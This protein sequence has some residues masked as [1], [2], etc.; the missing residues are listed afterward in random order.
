V[1]AVL[2]LCSGLA[3][4]QDARTVLQSATQAMGDVRSI[5]Y[6]GTGHNNALGQAYTPNTAWPETNV[7]SY[8]RTIDYASRSAK[9]ELTRI[10]QTPP[11]RGG[12]AAF[13]GEQRQVNLV[14][15]QFAWNQPGP[16]PQPALAAASERQLQ[17]WLTPHGFL[18]A[19][20]ENNATATRSQGGTVVSFTMGRFKVNGTIDGQNM[21][22]KTETWI[23]NPVLGDMQVETSF[24]G[25]RDYNGVK[26]PAA[27]VQRQGGYPVMDLV[28]TGVQANVE[29]AL[30]VPDAVRSATP[31][32]VTVQSQKLGEGLW[33]IGGGT[34]NSV[35][36]EY[37]NYLVIIDGP[38]GDARSLAVIAEAKNLVPNKPIRYLINTHSHFDH[39]GGVRAYVAEGATIITHEINRPFYEQAWRAPRTLE[40]DRLAQNPRNPTFLT[41]R[42]KYVLTDG[43]RSL[44]IYHREGDNHHAG[45]LIVYSPRE[46]VLMEADDFTP[47]AAN[48]PP[49]PPRAKGFTV[50]LYEHVQRLRLEV[51]T[52]A[53]MHGTV[54]PFAELQ[55]HGTT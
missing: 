50:A 13:A 55:K 37:P 53:P 35:L 6:S 28:V 8:T 7:T 54:V 23:P 52:I 40:P 18:K 41:V 34:H 27:I 16:A 48:A 26:F 10:E 24:S 5:Q 30:P 4:A 12:G 3:S 31:P 46:K 44:E 38:L 1:L 9:E 43:G 11:I 17:I 21:V 32:A 39:A 45:M 25:Y 51:T 2:L 14:S 47:P 20:L 15:G 19:A 36:A 22:T 33:F 49:L 42:D 29:L